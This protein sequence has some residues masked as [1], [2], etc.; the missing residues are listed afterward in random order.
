MANLVRCAARLLA[1]A[2]HRCERGCYVGAD[3][4]DRC[5]AGAPR[6]GCA[7]RGLYRG[8]LAVERGRWGSRALWRMVYF[9]CGV[10]RARRDR[11]LSGVDRSGRPCGLWLLPGGGNGR[12]AAGDI[13]LRS[14]PKRD[15]IR[16]VCR[17]G[18]FETL[19][20]RADRV[21]SQSGPARRMA[22]CRDA[23]GDGAGGAVRA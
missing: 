5:C 4:A 6:D 23:C 12:I 3:S 1:A 7:D 21:V 9:A 8:A 10:R 2:R 18:C 14:C 19:V 15:C 11:S 16:S 22:V 20:L 13:R 17:A